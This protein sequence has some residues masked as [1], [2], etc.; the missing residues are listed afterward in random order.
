[1][2]LP[3]EFK[4]LKRVWARGR[5]EHGRPTGKARLCRQI[6]GCRGLQI[7]VKWP[8]WRNS[9]PCSKGMEFSSSGRVGYIL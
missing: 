5:K 3:E 2:E 7:E 6:E 9:W 8:K 4:N 1:M